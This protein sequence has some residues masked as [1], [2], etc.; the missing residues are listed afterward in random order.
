MIWF[1]LVYLLALFIRQIFVVYLY[2]CENY[3]FNAMKRRILMVL[4]L[5]GSLGVKSQGFIHPGGLHT[6][7]DFDRTKAKIEANEEP[8]SAAY[9][10]LMT[11]KHVDLN[12]RPNPTEKIVRG[13]RTIWEPDP[14]NYWAAY[15]DVATAYQCALVWK[16]TGNTA[17]A[18]KSIEILNAWAK[19]CKKVSGDSNG[20]LAIGIYGYEFA[21]AGEIMRDYE[22]WKGEDFERYKEWMLTVFQ[23]GA[24]AFLNGRNGTYDDH[25]WSNWGLCNVMCA[26]SIGILCDDVFIYNAGMEYYKYMEDHRYA[27]SIM[28]LVWIL[29]EDDRGPFGYLGQMQESNRDQGHASMAVGLAAD[30]CGIGRN[31][32]DDLYAF[33]ND[34]I[35]AGFEYVSAYN[36]GVDDLPNTPYQNVDGTFPTMGTGGRG[37]SRCVMA[38]IVNYYEN[39]RGVEVPYCRELMMKD[40]GGIDAGGGFYGSTSGGYDHLGFTT[41]MCSLDPLT[42]KTAVPT[43]L[44]GEVS[45][46]GETY[47][48]PGVNCIPRGSVVKLRAF[49]QS[50]EEGTGQWSWD[51]D[52]ECKSN[53]REITLNTSGLYRVHYVNE[54]GVKSTQLFS[55]HVEGE[56]WSGPYSLYSK[57][58]GVEGSDSIVYVKKYGDV[59]VGLDYT[60]TLVRS[61]KWEKSNNG[62]TWNTMGDTGSQISLNGVTSDAYYRVTMTNRA[63]VQ[64]VQTFQVLVSEIDPY[65]IANEG[66]AYSGSSLAV[67]KG[68]DVILYASPNS[69]LSQSANSTRIY[70]WV[71]GNDTIRRTVLTSHENDLGQQVADLNDS[72]RITGLDSCFKCTLVF[73]RISQTG[74]RAETVYHFDIPVYERN[75]IRPTDD[76][77]YYIIDPLTGSYLRNTDGRFIGYNEENDGDFLWRI[78]RLTSL[79]GYRYMFISRTNSNTHL[80]ETGTLS[81]TSNYSAHSFNLLHKCSDENLY[82]IERNTTLGGLFAI[83]ADNAAIT[84][85]TAPCTDFPFYIVKKEDATGV[86]EVEFQSSGQILMNWRLDG[87]RLMLNVSEDGRMN[88][89][90]VSGNLL[91]TASCR[92]G[93]NTMILPRT[94]GV[95]I[96][97]YISESGRS[98]SIK[99]VMDGAND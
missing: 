87:E 86:E 74:S 44:D 56:G 47:A 53:E 18:D 25:Y 71:I 81:S 77:D 23:P 12:W 28:N 88:L 32:G 99:F 75:D 46:G 80:S 6:Q 57:V 59:T 27:E 41:L 3:K 65:V 4:M 35:A 39:V 26:V 7:E 38:R 29:Y 54:K 93:E 58:N 2:V 64:I 20:C 45:Y 95:I 52:P 1:R 48:R 13:G 96:G 85:G 36:A 8:W 91:N 62:R 89:Y 97:R 37:L 33:R 69:I 83:D 76:E 61:W 63:G 51:D 22:G 24:F 19:T 94:K 68:S 72:L 34:R 17:Y 30:L 31:Q 66:S 82:A 11:S 15:N 90:G 16:L 21:N 84:V 40:N 14:D 43:P 5:C 10:R 9:K 67:E 42:D 98:Q 55:L 92:Q 70:K 60:A 50:G 49:L 73:E 78:R 79:Y